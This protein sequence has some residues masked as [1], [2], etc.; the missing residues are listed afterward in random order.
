MSRN[1]YAM[2]FLYDGTGARDG[3]GRLCP[4][5]L[6]CPQMLRGLKDTAYP[7]GSV[8]L[9]E[10]VFCPGTKVPG[11]AWVIPPTLAGGTE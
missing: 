11:F 3:A 8:C 1:A 9:A 2:S 4:Y 6:V 5:V 7:A 10:V